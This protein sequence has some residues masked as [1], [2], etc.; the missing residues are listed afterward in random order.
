MRNGDPTL[1]SHG[2]MPES[3]FIEARYDKYCQ[4]LLMYLPGIGSP[5]F[6]LPAEAWYAWE[7]N[8]NEYAGIKYIGT[9]LLWTY[10]YPHAWA[11]FRQRREDRGSRADYFGNSILATRAHR[12]FCMDLAREYPGYSDNI[13]GISSSLSKTGYKACGG[14]PRR[15]GIDG[16]VVPCAA[17]GSLMFTPELSLAA[18]RTM[19]E[20]F[21][22]KI[23]GRYGFTDAFHPTNGWASEDVIG[24]DVGITLLSAENLRSGNVSKWFMANPEMQR[25][26]DLAGLHHE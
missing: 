10:Q 12:A 16:T 26:M 19:K 5:A 25:A 20:R 2:W 17:A 3:G 1:L 14:P 24:L 18:L 11:Y 6:A 23:W 7:R 22:D 13:W 8:P 15:K 21:G 9:S 4:L